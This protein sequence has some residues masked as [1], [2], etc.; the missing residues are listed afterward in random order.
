MEWILELELEADRPKNQTP[1][2]GSQFYSCMEGLIPGS[3]LVLFISKMGP[4][5]G[6]FFL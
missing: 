6:F 3:L 4:V 1:K 5:L 2:A